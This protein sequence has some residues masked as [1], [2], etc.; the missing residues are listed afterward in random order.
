M[1]H[2]PETTAGAHEPG[3]QHPAE[4]VDLPVQVQDLVQG[5]VDA[6]RVALVVPA[7]APYALQLAVMVTVTT[8][9]VQEELIDAPVLDLLTAEKVRFASPEAGREQVMVKVRPEGED[10]RLL[11]DV[12][13]PSLVEME[14]VAEEAWIPVKIKLLLLHIVVITYLPGGGGSAEVGGGSAPEGLPAGCPPRSHTPAAFPVWCLGTSSACWS[15]GSSSGLPHSRGPQPPHSPG[16][17]SLVRF[18]SPW[19]LH[20]TRMETNIPTWEELPVT[21]ATVLKM[22][23]LHLKSR[24]DLTEDLM[25]HDS[26]VG[27]VASNTFTF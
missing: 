5:R 26:Q 19:L 25:E 22:I 14:D 15:R 16:G 27:H 2:V 13:L 17:S 8:A 11:H 10:T 12:E 1:L 6:A 3:H 23:L 7:A 18:P 24:R 21:T 20:K 9:T 4:T